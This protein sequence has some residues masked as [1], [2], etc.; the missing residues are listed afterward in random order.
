MRSPTITAMLLAACLA[1]LAAAA[2]GPTGPAPVLLLSTGTTLGSLQIVELN[3]VRLTP[4]GYHVLITTQFDRPVL[5]VNGSIH[6][7][8]GQSIPATGLTIDS[9][10]DIGDSSAAGQVATV[11]RGKDGSG[12]KRTVVLVDGLLQLEEGQLVQAAGLPA[13]ATWTLLKTVVFDADGELVV[14]GAIE[15]PTVSLIYEEA[16]VR[17]DVAPNGTLSAGV[18]LLASGQAVDDDLTIRILIP[19]IKTSYASRDP[20]SLLATVG[21]VNGAGTAFP[22]AVVRDGVPLIMDG[23]PSPLPDRHWIVAPFDPVE[24][25]AVGRWAA[26]VAVSG[27]PFGS[28]PAIVRDDLLWAVQGEPMPARPATQVQGLNWARLSD[29]GNM[30]WDARFLDDGDTRH[31]LMLNDQVLVEEGVSTS[32][33]V[34]LDALSTFEWGQFDIQPDGTSILF[35]ASKAGSA[36]Q[37]LF[38]MHVGPW[39]S[40]GH[41]LPDA[42]VGPKLVANG[43]QFPGA[44]TRVEIRDGLP[45]APAG[46][47]LG[48]SELG[49]PFKGGVLCPAPDLVVAGLVLDAQ[50][51]FLSVFPFPV[52]V[53][54]GTE[55][56]W[57]GWVVDPL[58]PQGL[59][60][61]N[62]LVS[63]VP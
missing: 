51:G 45:L 12:G 32:G 31:V 27:G 10:Y 43:S 5:L 62:C 44:V 18:A 6:H 40:L 55:F 2:D 28:L 54:S 63:F 4:G 41:G 60:A 36:Q 37:H 9:L 58:G 46:I 16:F 30:L 19:N 49:A 7:F 61:T 52:G 56:Y 13:G 20:G 11:V 15:D 59:T 47:I 29:T 17:Y 50:G 57:Q 38:A 53:P 33:G 39:V 35:I 48:L 34:T 8:I 24:Q 26:R 1:P 23:Q 25:D 14:G 3:E 21:L 22:D 42:S